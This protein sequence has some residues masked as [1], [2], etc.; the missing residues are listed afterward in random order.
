MYI[1]FPRAT[2]EFHLSASHQEQFNKN[3]APLSEQL[4]A[5]VAEP[6]STY[7]CLDTIVPRNSE[8]SSKSAGGQFKPQQL[9]F[10]VHA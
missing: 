6:T 9:S 2:A 5:P 1:R 4:N 10:N 3:A 7:T 8:S